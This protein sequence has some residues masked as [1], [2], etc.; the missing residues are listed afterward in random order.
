MLSFYTIF[1]SFLIIGGT[2]KVKLRPFMDEAFF[3]FIKNK[4]Y[5]YIKLII[6]ANNN[7]INHNSKNSNLTN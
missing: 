6:F 7:E 2:A 4:N 3:I 5:L 1:L